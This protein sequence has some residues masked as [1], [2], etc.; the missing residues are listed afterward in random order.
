MLQRLQWSM[1]QKLDHTVG[2]IDKFVRMT[3]GKAYVAFSAGKD[4]LVLLD[5]ARRFVNKNILAVFDNTGM[6]YPESVQYAMGFSNLEIVKP[7]V[8]IKQMIN[9]IGFPLVSKDISHKLAI[10]RKNMNGKYAEKLLRKRQT[11]GSNRYGYLPYK[12]R[13]LLYVPY[14]CSEACCYHLKKHP[15]AKFN[16]EKGLFPMI[17][18]TVAESATRWAAVQ[19]VGGCIVAR[20]NM[21]KATPISFWTDDDIWA[22]INRFQLEVNPLYTEHNFQRTGC[23]FCG[24]GAQY[25]SDRRFVNLFNIHRNIYKACM[26]YTNNGCSYRMALTQIGANLPEENIQ[27]ELF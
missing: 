17:A 8:P 22:Y 26:S 6:E 23:M 13:F 11:D 2:T 3:N 15:M 7:K 9:K 24:F 5:I 18:T 21:M 4:S 12:W 10:M 14:N 20:G 27:G 19:R 1:E 16:A 25:K